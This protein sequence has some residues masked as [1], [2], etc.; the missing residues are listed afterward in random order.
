[1]ITSK[2]RKIY[3]EGNNYYLTMDQL[4]NYY[5]PKHITSSECRIQSI[6]TT[7]TIN[8]DTIT[9]IPHFIEKYKTPII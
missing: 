8:G 2:P 4:R 3:E 1:M 5:C 6:G 7:I 9:I